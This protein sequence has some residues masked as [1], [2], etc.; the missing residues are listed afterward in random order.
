[1]SRGAFLGPL[2]ALVEFVH[3]KGGLSSQDSR[4]VSFKRT[5]GGGRKAFM[6]PNLGLREWSVSTK[7]LGPE[8]FAQFEL[9]A[10]G[11]YGSPP[12]WWVDPAAQVTNVLSPRMSMPGFGNEFAFSGGSAGTMVIP[13]LGPVP[14]V[15]VPAGA[16]LKVALA[17]PVVAGVPLTGAVYVSGNSAGSIRAQFL[18]SSG[19]WTHDSVS[20]VTFGA[21]ARISTSSVARDG[22]QTLDLRITSAGAFTVALPSVTWTPNLLPWSKG[23]GARRTVVHG[24]SDEVVNADATTST[25]RIIDF[26]FTVTEVGDGA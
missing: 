11:A 14:A 2:G 6:G 15:T 26:S 3:Y 22:D 13:G 25:G 18:N 1:M 4:D 17:T 5:L 12:F 7:G 19:T 20:Q 9:L 10:A 23:R 16:I 8:Q 21:P 24:I